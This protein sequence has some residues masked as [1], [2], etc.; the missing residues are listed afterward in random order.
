[1]PPA[2]PSSRRLDLPNP[3]HSL[4]GGVRCQATFETL[5]VPDTLKRVRKGA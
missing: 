2:A 1:M 3:R 5:K 4:P